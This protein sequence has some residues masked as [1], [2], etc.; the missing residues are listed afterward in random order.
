VPVVKFQ[1]EIVSAPPRRAILSLLTATR[2][3]TAR[4]APQCRHDM[5]RC[6]PLDRRLAE[7]PVALVGSKEILASPAIITAIRIVSCQSS[8]SMT[9]HPRSMFCAACT[10]HGRNVVKE[11]WPRQIPNIKPTLIQCGLAS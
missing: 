5:V 7:S 8:V 6:T 2:E 1:S 3:E 9:D 4:S 10:L 11:K